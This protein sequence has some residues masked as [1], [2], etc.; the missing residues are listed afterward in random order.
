MAGYFKI[1]K[2][3]D[4]RHKV[5]RH[6]SKVYSRTSMQNRTTI[7]IHHS[8]TRRKLPGSNAEAY[9]HYH[10]NSHGW[11]SIGYHYVIEPDGTIKFCN[12]LEYVTYHVGNHNG[13]A[14]GICLTG[15]FRYE[16]PTPEQEESL[17][18]LVAAIQ[19]AYPHIKTIK[20]HNEFKGYEWKQCPEFDFRAVLAKRSSSKTSASSSKSIASKSLPGTYVIQQGDTF[21][22]I[23]KGLPGITVDDLIK[24]NPG[25]D[26]R[27]LKVGQ[28]INLGTAK[29]S[30]SSSK[31]TSGSSSKTASS[32][33]IKAGQKVTLKTTASR[34]ATG[35]L[36]PARYKG[37]TYTVQQVKSDRV[38]L[39][40]LYSWVKISDISA[41]STTTVTSSRASTSKTIKVGSKVRLKTSAT[42]YATG[43][44]IPARYKG[45]TF[46]VQ[47][48][49][50]DRVLLK[51]LYSWVK[52][53]DV[54]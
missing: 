32:S 34:Y 35:E 31:S 53:S 48:V 2:L 21:W 27:K 3:I 23:A 39:K 7:A 5:V 44:P 10:V 33:S 13:Y 22:S 24:A 19:K 46:T 9:S 16:D 43:E 20:G 54:E 12:D 50:T 14:I 4:F 49:K 40:E 42:R 29:K 18:N 52:R 8:L 11:P 45:K 28:K 17:R 26:P 6:K 37:K 47:Q 25:V 36:I 15:D 38:L 1:P 30:N 51:E 41:G